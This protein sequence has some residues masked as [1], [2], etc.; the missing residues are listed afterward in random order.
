MT[1]LRGRYVIIRGA[2]S[3]VFAGVLIDQDDHKVELADCRR[4]WSW[5]GAATVSQ[6]ALE[7]VKKP[8]DCRFT[9]T[10]EQLLILDAV[11]IVPCTAE[12]ETN[13]KAVPV[14]AA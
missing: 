8:E 12:A 13:I 6:I 10:V 14:W 7:G 11:E 3:G 4:I 5:A 1:D 9:V 2:Q